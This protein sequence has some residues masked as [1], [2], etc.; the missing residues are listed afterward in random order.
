MLI[1]R[2]N[3]NIFLDVCYSTI[4]ECALRSHC[5]QLCSVIFL[6]L[7]RLMI[8]LR[9]IWS[10]PSELLSMQINSL[11]IEFFSI[12]IT[13]EIH[14]YN[15]TVVP[16]P[17][18]IDSMNFVV[19]DFLLCE[20]WDICIH[21]EIYHLKLSSLVEAICYILVQNEM[22]RNETKWNKMK[23][24]Q[25]MSSKRTLVFIDY[26]IFIRVFLIRIAI[27]WNV[28]QLFSNKPFKYNF[29]AFI[30][31]HCSWNETIKMLKIAMMC[32]NYF[33]CSRVGQI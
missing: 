9:E 27:I 21:D 18:F 32:D 20:V 19:Y 7:L 11:E 16:V 1:R 26:D 33:V 31:L 24:T 2:H 14:A 4:N 8:W 6:L 13:F 10:P 12:F 22:K 29:T 23:Q 28:N 3:G 30:R 15:T 25:E 5:W 17:H